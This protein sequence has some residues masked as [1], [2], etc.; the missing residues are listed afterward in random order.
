VDRVLIVLALAAAVGVAAA[1]FR[2]RRPAPAPARVD[3]ADVGVSAPGGTVVVGFS[4]PWC[5]PCRAWESALA[6]TGVRF[7]KVDL[8]ERPD[9]ARKYDVRSTPLLLALSREGD[10]IETFRGDPTAEAV[11]RVT[12]LAGG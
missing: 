2:A 6:G 9:L 7:A 5:A 8:T 3:L 1:F 12:S 4:T 10:V 11:S